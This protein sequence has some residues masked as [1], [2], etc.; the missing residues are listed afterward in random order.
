MRATPPHPIKLTNLFIYLF[1]SRGSFLRILLISKNFASGF[2]RPEKNL[3]TRLTQRY[4]LD[5]IS[6]FG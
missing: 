3:P 1:S 6:I 5:L 4:V 2:N